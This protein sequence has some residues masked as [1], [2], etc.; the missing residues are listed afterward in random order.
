MDL[1][2]PNGNNA[3]YVKLKQELEDS[4]IYFL[5]QLKREVD[6]EDHFSRLY[7]DAKPEND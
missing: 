2:M 4:N 1:I 5:N 6:G 3:S 7:F